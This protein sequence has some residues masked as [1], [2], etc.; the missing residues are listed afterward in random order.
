MRDD[1]SDCSLCRLMRS[2]AFSGLGMSIGFGVAYISG[3]SKEN[4]LLSGIVLAAI[5]VFGVIDKRTKD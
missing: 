4:S 2:V 5:M 1:N 3:V